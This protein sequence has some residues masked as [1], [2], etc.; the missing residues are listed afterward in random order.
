MAETGT[1]V[2]VKKTEEKQPAPPAPRG[3]WRPFESLVAKSIVCLRTSTAGSDDFRSAARSSTSNHPGD[4]TSRRRP[5]RLSMLR[6]RTR[7]MRSRRSC[8]GW[9]RPTSR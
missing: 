3:E 9:T 4:L 6:K 1:K 5:R 7:S 8:R 2:P